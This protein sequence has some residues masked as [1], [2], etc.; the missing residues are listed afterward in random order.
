MSGAST[1]GSG[2]GR[3]RSGRDR[4]SSP[5]PDPRSK[6]GR[7]ANAR[8]A[9]FVRILG[10]LA[11]MASADT[12]RVARSATLPPWV[13]ELRAARGRRGSNWGPP[14]SHVDNR[15][16]KRE[17]E[18]DYASEDML[19][20]H[21]STPCFGDAD[22]TDA[23][24][25]ESSIVSWRDL[26][27]RGDASRPSSILVRRVPADPKDARRVIP[28]VGVDGGRAARCTSAAQI[29]GH[30]VKRKWDEDRSK[31]NE[32]KNPITNEN[33]DERTAAIVAVQMAAWS[34]AP[35]GS[36]DCAARFRFRSVPRRPGA[37]SVTLELDYY[38]T[39]LI[40]PSNRSSALVP[41]LSVHLG[42]LPD[43]SRFEKGDDVHVAACRNLL[44]DVVE[45]LYPL[46][47]TGACF[48]V[49]RARRR[50]R[51]D[52]RSSDLHCWDEPSC[53]NATAT[54]VTADGEQRSVPATT[55]GGHDPETAI[56]M[57]GACEARCDVENLGPISWVSLF[58]TTRLRMMRL[59]RRVRHLKRQ[60]WEG[61]ITISEYEE[62]VAEVNFQANHVLQVAPHELKT[63][64]LIRSMAAGAAFWDNNV[65]ARDVACRLLAVQNA[66]E[67][68]EEAE[69]MGPATPGDSQFL[70][71][72]L[73]KHCVSGPAAPRR[74]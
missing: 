70:R 21:L 3:K 58:G 27:A 63:S 51:V 18:A 1:S 38:D 9:E 29:L 55:E 69:G 12:D 64:L 22:H 36:P 40:A 20:L 62:G 52:Q 37:V 45:R 68:L 5:E 53:W 46:A 35:R 17:E 74:S 25:L 23:V 24:T 56:N 31:F 30:L 8:D 2:V 14:P 32:V 19:R 15:R 13:E 71:K 57:P 60:L 11:D 50:V 42:H 26:D 48:D 54:V 67:I 66:I 41:Q 34:H 65:P 4:S 72:E 59:E 28:L 43:P 33:L 6:R 39:R 16:N 7:T 47:I 49:V 10:E 44:A 73:E 61:K